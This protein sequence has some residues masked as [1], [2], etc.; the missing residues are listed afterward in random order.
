MERFHLIVLALLSAVITPV[1]GI[2]TSLTAGFAGTNKGN[3]D[4]FPFMSLVPVSSLDSHYDCQTR[5]FHS[6]WK[7]IHHHCQESGCVDYQL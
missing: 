6:K 1:H 4:R 5:I 7:H 3:F 2:D